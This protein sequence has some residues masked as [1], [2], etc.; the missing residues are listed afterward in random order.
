MKECNATQPLLSVNI[1]RKLYE[2]MSA[3][4]QNIDTEYIS[5][6]FNANLLCLFSYSMCSYNII[7]QNEVFIVIQYVGTLSTWVGLRKDNGLD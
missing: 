6:M 5:T 2:L 7:K 1:M 3:N 4:L